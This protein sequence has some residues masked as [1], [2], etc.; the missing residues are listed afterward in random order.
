LFYYY[1]GHDPIGAGVDL[2][3]LAVLAAVALAGTAAAALAIDR[4]D[5]R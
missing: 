5:L 3:D 4:R 2:G 1:E